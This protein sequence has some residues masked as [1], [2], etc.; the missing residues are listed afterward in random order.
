MPTSKAAPACRLA[1]EDGTVFRG[2]SFG[3]C[4]DGASAGG[5]VVFNTAMC[6]YQEAITDP[7]YTGQILT[8]TAPEMGNY[9]VAA[10]DV[11]SAAAAVRGFVVREA[12][13]E[14]SNHRATSG[15]SEW[16]AASGVIGLTGI[17]TRAL[18]GS[19]ASRARSAACC[20]SATRRPTRNWSRWRAPCPRWPGRTSPGA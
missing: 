18:C 17:D 5:E 10:E 13:L 15:L 2:R 7:S 16:L 14:P 12:V 8:M 20:S 6:G 1:L 19:S 4:T 11:E 9:G 3:F